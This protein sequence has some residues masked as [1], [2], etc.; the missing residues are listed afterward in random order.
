MNHRI[1]ARIA[2][3]AVT[4]TAAAAVPA[5]TPARMQAILQEGNGGPEVL[6]LRSVAIPEPAAGQVLIR[7][8]AASVN[9]IDWKLRSGYRPAGSPP[10][11]N[12]PG[13]GAPPPGGGGAVPSGPAAGAPPG[14]GAAAAA[15][16]PGLDVAG[17]VEKVGPGVTQFKPGD[18]V[19]SMIGRADFGLNGAYAQY[20]LAPLDNVV[21]KP[22]NLSYAEAAGLGTT[23]MTAARILARVGV[24]S[25][26][27]VL[28]TGAAGGVGS[29]VAQI[30]RARGAHVIGTAS[31]RH[32]RYL[33]SIGV[34]EV[35]DYTQGPFEDKVKD[36]DV[37]IDTV[38]GETATRALETLRRG[39]SFGTV[40]GRV[41][42]ALCTAA[43]VSCAAGGPPGS[44]EPSEGELL[45]QVA[46]LAAAGR[47]RV[48]VDRTFP[49]AR[50]ADAQEYNRAGH[51]EG[52]VILV[53]DAQQATRR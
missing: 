42:P 33:G 12:A 45:R 6:H 48:H 46:E 38:G 11:G 36:V 28:V 7:V 52:K 31:A 34:E 35:V 50:A 15:R 40:A 27:R 19:F 29:A 22:K 13:A 8:Y 16:I 2:L 30:A 26:Q 18:A 4:W 17:V 44:G 43:G 21:A 5:A 47:F 24:A 14:D 20:T 10:A 53:V 25:G 1:A 37:V 49:L 51:T 23:G 41:D 32:A 3:F 9:P 39:G